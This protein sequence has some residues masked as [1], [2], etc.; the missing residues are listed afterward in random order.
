MAKEMGCSSGAAR[1]FFSRYF[2]LSIPSLNDLALFPLF[3]ALGRY[4]ALSL[5]NRSYLFWEDFCSC[6]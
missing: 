2:F 4:G 3:R 6:E 1:V 5:F